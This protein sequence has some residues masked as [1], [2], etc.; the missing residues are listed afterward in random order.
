MKIIIAILIALAI[1]VVIVG[2]G[3]KAEQT[4]VEVNTQPKE[5]APV[6]EPKAAPPA[7][8]SEEKIK[9]PQGFTKTP[10]GLM[11]K[12]IKVGTGATAKS[13]EKVTVN[14]K[15]WLDNGTVFDTSKKPGREPLEF[16]LGAGQVI[17]GWDEGVQGMKV[18]GVRE[19]IIP[20]DLGYGSIEMGAIPPNSTLHF[21]VELL[22]VGS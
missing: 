1:I 19:L 21:Q 18:G 6:E 11:Y 9:V 7:S 8:K 10:S 3:K 2:C 4:K 15:G 17:P 14:Y 12:D 5:T 16:S 22:K 20:P 13:G